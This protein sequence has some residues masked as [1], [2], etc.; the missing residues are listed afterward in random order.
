MSSQ[1]R[2]ASREQKAT[3]A[4]RLLTL[5]A[6]RPTL[7]SARYQLQQYHSLLS[8]STAVRKLQVAPTSWRASQVITPRL[9]RSE[10]NVWGILVLVF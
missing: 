2:R 3:V 4:E 7:L 1:Q 9:R 5:S 8:T 10:K 6:L